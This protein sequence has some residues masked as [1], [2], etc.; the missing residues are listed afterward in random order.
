MATKNSL[1]YKFL[2]HSQVR[3]TLAVLAAVIAFCMS[4]M[5]TPTAMAQD[6]D[7]EPATPKGVPAGFWLTPIRPSFEHCSVAKP[8]GGS[9]AF[10]LKLE[11]G[12]YYH[13]NVS[14][15][16]A[17]AGREANV[18]LR[19]NGST[20]LFDGSAFVYDARPV[21]SDGGACQICVETSGDIWLNGLPFGD[22]EVV[23]P[24]CSSATV[25][26]FE[27]MPANS[28]L[29]FAI[30][31]EAE[32]GVAGPPYP[33][34]PAATEAEE[35]VF[36]FE[37]GVVAQGED[38][39]AEALGWCELAWWV[40]GDPGEYVSWFLAEEEVILGFSGTLSC[41]PMKPTMDDLNVEHTYATIEEAS[42]YGVIF[43]PYVPVDFEP[44]K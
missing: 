10:E 12:K 6:C 26:S 28:V 21:V 31:G 42:N 34:A 36:E 17:A 29:I 33:V 14:V 9:P 23:E 4:F 16:G 19:G 15:R 24:P 43:T 30:N 3:V 40:P 32:T 38:L 41:W 8:L 2:G 20:V 39:A 7:P 1:I 22:L 5:F 18:M 35:P 37:A 27:E 11:D 13:L 44:V 25:M